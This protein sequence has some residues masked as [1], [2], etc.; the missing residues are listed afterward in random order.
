MLINIPGTNR[1]A[2][3]NNISP[4]NFILLY[5]KLVLVR[6]QICPDRHLSDR[7]ININVILLILWGNE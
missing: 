6:I 4:L 7:I 1:A 2:Q 3:F 5:L